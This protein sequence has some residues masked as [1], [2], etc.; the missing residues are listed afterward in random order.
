MS[1]KAVLWGLISLSAATHQGYGSPHAPTVSTSATGSVIWTTRVTRR[2]LLPPGSL[3]VVDRGD[4]SGG[5]RRPLSWAA[6]Q[7]PPW[8][9][10]R[11]EM[12]PRRWQTATKKAQQNRIYCNRL[13][14]VFRQAAFGIIFECHT[15]P[16]A[17]RDFEQHFG[18]TSSRSRSM[19][20]RMARIIVLIN[21]WSG[22][23]SAVVRIIS[24]Y[25]NSPPVFFGGG[26]AV[27]STVDWLI[28]H[29]FFFVPVIIHH[30][31]VIFLLWG[32]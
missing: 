20:L 24:I 14:G 28:D 5:C 8:Y 27:C 18:I 9:N 32:N 16:L 12:E 21:L 3:S 22:R 7:L 4:I 30:L 26:G 13:R 25:L 31:E 15:E 2:S 19:E 29:V 6:C 1:C 10:K 11:I 17:R 23:V